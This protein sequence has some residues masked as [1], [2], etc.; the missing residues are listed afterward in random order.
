M[1]DMFNGATAFNQDIGK[2]EFPKV[3]SMNKMFKGATSFK[4]DISE[5][6]VESVTYTEDMFENCPI[7]DE[8]KPKVIR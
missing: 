8:Y 4:Q 5:W 3:I 2:W 7:K 6:D 1:N